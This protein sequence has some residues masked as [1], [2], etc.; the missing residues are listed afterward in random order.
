MTIHRIGSIVPQDSNIF[1]LI[2]ESTM[3]IDTGTGIMS[4]PVIEHVASLLNGKK[5][6]SIVLTH[7]HYD[8][9]GGLKD[10]ISAFEPA[11][12]AGSKDA[13][14][15][16]KGGQDRIFR[17]DISPCPDLKELSDGN[18]ID[19]GG[20]LLEIIETPGHTKGGICLFDHVTGS[21]FSGDTVFSE[22]VG[23]TDFEGGDIRE[24]RKSLHRLKELD[25]IDLYP[26][27]GPVVMGSGKDSIIKGLR[28]TGE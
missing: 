18:S 28:Y 4:G 27:H 19:L 1:L 6:N 21:L 11:V 25:V 23:R 8:H 3:L 10:F 14:I 26:G 2:G 5:L 20:H 24:L 12:F 7:H 17:V 15:I 9:I 22:G 13:S 16:R